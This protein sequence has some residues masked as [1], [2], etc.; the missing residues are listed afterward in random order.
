MVFF[1][2]AFINEVIRA[3]WVIETS[4]L[5]IFLSIVKLWNLHNKNRYAYW[6]HG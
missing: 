1:A 3:E 4:M 6:S 5:G 2:E